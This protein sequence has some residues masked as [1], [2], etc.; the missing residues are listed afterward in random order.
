VATIPPSV[1]RLATAAGDLVLGARCAGCGEPWWG[2]CPTCAAVLTAL[3]PAPTRPDPA[4]PG[5]PP[6]VTAG[7]YDDRQRGL[8]TAHKEDQ[9]LQLTPLLG[10]LLA[11]SVGLLA[12]VAGLTSA[13]RIVLVGVP[14]ARAALRRRGFD[15]TRALGRRA[16]GVLR[17]RFAGVSLAPLLAQR[18]GTED[19]AGLNAAERLAN[20]SGSMRLRRGSLPAGPVILIDDV[21][22]TGASLAEA[23][24]VLR[25]ADVPLIGACTIAATVRHSLRGR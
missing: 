25:A 11:G 3:A 16:A 22:T 18:R 5:F 12:D 24:R 4:P 13:D 17:S 15:P 10:R 6:T 9:A 8:I 20:L 21:V 1:L 23:A 19:Q 14:S 7:P 2:A